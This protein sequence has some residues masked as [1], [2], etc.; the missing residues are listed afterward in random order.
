MPD[1]TDGQLL[2]EFIERGTPAAFEQLVR[3]HMDWVYSCARRM[4]RDD[5]M[6]E[7]VAQAVFILL[8]RKARS[9]RGGGFHPDV[10][11]SARRI[12]PPRLAGSL[13]E[14]CARCGARSLSRHG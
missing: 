6:A 9:L 13:R 8:L 5:H 2:G 12:H 3:R 7:D 11:A 1:F 4:L 14:G 10:R